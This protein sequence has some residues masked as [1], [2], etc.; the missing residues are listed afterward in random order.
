[1]VYSNIYSKALYTVNKHGKS[2]FTV[3]IV[4]C[5]KPKQVHTQFSDAAYDK[6]P[7]QCVHHNMNIAQKHGKTLYRFKNMVNKLLQ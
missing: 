2:W 6:S 5:V 1:M 3:K 7:D 4:Y